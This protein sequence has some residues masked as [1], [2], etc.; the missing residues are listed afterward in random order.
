MTKIDRLLIAFPGRKYKNEKEF[1]EKREILIGYGLAKDLRNLNEEER[2]S[3]IKKGVKAS[4]KKLNNL[5][6]LKE[7]VKISFFF[8]KTLKFAIYPLK[9]K[10]RKSQSKLKLVKLTNVFTFNAN[11]KDD[12]MYFGRKFHEIGEINNDVNYS[13]RSGVCASTNPKIVDLVNKYLS[14]FKYQNYESQQEDV[15]GEDNLVNKKMI[16]HKKF[17]RDIRFVNKFK[18][19][20]SYINNCE[21]CNKDYYKIYKFISDKVFYELHHIQ[22]LKNAKQFQEKIIL[23]R[24]NVALLCPNCHRAIHRYM[25]EKKQETISI[26]KFQSLLKF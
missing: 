22:P 26:K 5:A 1:E 25:N 17:E 10:G 16:V 20:Y 11:R 23:S 2:L 14:K 3:E 15:E 19:L 9:S 8:D 12:T 21:G 18:K 13:I 24:K 4:N 6:I 7:A